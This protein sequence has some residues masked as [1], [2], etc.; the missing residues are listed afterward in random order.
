MTDIL[1]VNGFETDTD[2][3]SGSLTSEKLIFDVQSNIHYK[4]DG[5]DELLGDINTVFDFIKHHVQ[6][7]IFRLSVLDDYYKG[8]NTAL[9]TANRRL[10]ENKSDHRIA[11]NLR[12]LSRNSR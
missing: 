4:A 5:I 3:T 9:F 10:T 2:T 8:R 11:H 1:K 6:N 12:R 7:Q